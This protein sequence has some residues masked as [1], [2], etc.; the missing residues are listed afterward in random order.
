MMSGCLY[1][2]IR[3]ALRKGKQQAP[4]PL[5]LGRLRY[6]FFLGHW[7]AIGQPEQPP[8]L[9]PRRRSHQTAATA[10]AASRARSI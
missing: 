9:L 1:P 5:W 6:F 4:Q 7:P 8:Q 2:I 3:L 10:R